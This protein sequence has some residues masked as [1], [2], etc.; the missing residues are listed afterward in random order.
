LLMNG[1]EP[2]SISVADLAVALLDEVEQPQ[3]IR[4]RFTLAY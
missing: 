2:G 3:H 1:N 4:Q